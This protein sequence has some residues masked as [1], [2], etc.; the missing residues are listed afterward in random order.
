MALCLERAPWQMA[1]Q[2]FCAGLLSILVVVAL[3]RAPLV[4]DLGRAPLVEIWQAV[5]LVADLGMAPLRGLWQAVL[6]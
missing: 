6:C 5:P 1:S 2:L 4:A 3:G